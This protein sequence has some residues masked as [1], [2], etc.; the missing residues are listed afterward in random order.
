MTAHEIS[1]FSRQ[2][3]PSDRIAWEG[4]QPG[5][6][7]KRVDIRDFIQRNYSPY[8][9]DGSFLA[10]PTERTKKIWQKVLDLYEEERKKGVLDVDPA[11][12]S[13][14]TAFG[15]GYIDKENERIVGL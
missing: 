7:Q 1:S 11:V 13:S 4:F 12:A 9:G 15:P 5:E 6:W 3:S 8:E 2:I 10:G 14:V